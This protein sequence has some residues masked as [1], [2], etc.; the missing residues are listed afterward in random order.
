M[1]IKDPWVILKA[2]A[3]DDTIMKGC[4]PVFIGRLRAD[5]EVVVL[6]AACMHV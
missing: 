1:R 5:E 3:V 2:H 6:I 4:A